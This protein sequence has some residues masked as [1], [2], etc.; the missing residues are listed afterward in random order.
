MPSLQLPPFPEQVIDP[1]NIAGIQYAKVV[2]LSV[3]NDKRHFKGIL[4]NE[5]N[6]RHDGLL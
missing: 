6:H 3:R 4:E 2:I 1:P 5:T